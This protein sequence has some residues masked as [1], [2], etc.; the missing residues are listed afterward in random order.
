MTII[1]LQNQPSEFIRPVGDTVAEAAAKAAAVE[2]VI[3]DDA[4]VFV[5]L[6]VAK[7]TDAVVLVEV[8]AVA[9]TMSE[10]DELS[11]KSSTRFNKWNKHLIMN[12][13]NNCKCKL[14]LGLLNRLIQV[15]ISNANIKVNNDNK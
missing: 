7:I 15:S 2:V 6:N 9:T 12:D 13:I 10:S 4:V 5:V 11:V 14:F 3:K 8:S 1:N